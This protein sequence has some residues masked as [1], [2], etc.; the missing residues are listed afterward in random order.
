MMIWLDVLLCSC[1]IGFEFVMV[2]YVL[3]SGMFKGFV[4]FA[5]FIDVNI[6]EN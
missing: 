3:S 2:E 6:K 4:F 5:V 1:V